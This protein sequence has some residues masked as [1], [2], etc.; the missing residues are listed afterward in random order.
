MHCLQSLVLYLK[1]FAKKSKQVTAEISAAEV[2]QG[3]QSEGPQY[4]TKRDY[5]ETQ[6]G[7][8]TVTE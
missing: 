1:T 4:S 8:L 2:Q 6:L 3:S 7:I 5:T